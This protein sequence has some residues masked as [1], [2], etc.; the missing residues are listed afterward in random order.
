[1]GSLLLPVCAARAATFDDVYTKYQQEGVIVACSFT[2]A[3]LL[4]ALRNIPA[5]IRAYD[6]GFEEGLS[7][8]LIARGDGCGAFNR[9][10]S[11]LAPTLPGAGI[12]LAADGSP[13]PANAAAPRA[14]S[15]AVRGALGASANESS[16]PIPLILAGLGIVLPLGAALVLALGVNLKPPGSR[17]S[18][19]RS[20]WPPHERLADAVF[21]LR[22]RFGR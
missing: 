13:G 15:A 18:R 11:T 8:A 22:D 12:V 4:S 19:G 5:D 6:P 17:G 10:P 14:R 21:V 2:R 7:E 1:M 16:L 3:E 20:S 9:A